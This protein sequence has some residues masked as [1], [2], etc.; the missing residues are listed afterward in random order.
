LFGV[1][2]GEYLNAGDLIKIKT[3][4]GFGLGTCL[5][6]SFTIR[7]GD[8]D[9]MDTIRQAFGVTQPLDAVVGRYIYCGNEED[10][11]AEV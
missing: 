11:T 7:D 4:E 3:K 9:K 8:T 2:N 6:D 5:C 1:P 10:S